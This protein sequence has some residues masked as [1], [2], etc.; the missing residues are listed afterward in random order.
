M[1]ISPCNLCRSITHC[2]T[3]LFS[4]LLRQHSSTYKF[5]FI[6]SSSLT[7]PLQGISNI[8]ITNAFKDLQTHSH[9]RT[10]SLSEYKINF[11]LKSVS[12]LL[13]DFHTHSPK[14]RTK[15][16]TLKLGQGSNNWMGKPFFF[17]DP[18]QLAQIVHKNLD[19][20][21]FR[22]YLLGKCI[23]LHFIV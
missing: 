2:F 6:C 22:T 5:R 16:T 23:L 12:Y 10:L 7:S 4:S 1:K 15:P 8:Q 11:P 21:L 19:A 14:R 18:N 3:I 17:F 9:T 13:F 20:L